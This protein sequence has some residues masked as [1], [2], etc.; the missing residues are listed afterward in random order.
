MTV[1]HIKKDDKHIFIG[2]EIYEILDKYGLTAATENYSIISSENYKETEKFKQIDNIATDGEK[3]YI[4]SNDS[5]PI[6][7]IEEEIK[8]L[9]LAYP[10]IVFSNRTTLST[11]VD[12]GNRTFFVEF[13][14]KNARIHIPGGEANIPRKII[15]ETKIGSIVPDLFNLVLEYGGTINT[16]MYSKYAYSLA[17]EKWPELQIIPYYDIV[18][19]IDHPLVYTYDGES[20]NIMHPFKVN[21]DLQDFIPMKDK[22]ILIKT[23]LFL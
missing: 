12:L 9:K 15:K 3:L 21:L 19:I 14:K 10:Y 5:P 8:D 2:K 11:F 17:T 23:L 7:K 20:A 1:L 4:L 13:T 22:E 16:R 6:E 18:I